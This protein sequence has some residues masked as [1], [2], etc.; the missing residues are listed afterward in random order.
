[1]LKANIGVVVVVVR[2]R[3]DSGQRIINGAVNV[4]RMKMSEHCHVRMLNR[5]SVNEIFE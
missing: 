4:N 1:M 5:A 2:G 3:D